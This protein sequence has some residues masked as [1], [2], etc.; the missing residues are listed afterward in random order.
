MSLV[1]LRG[2]ESTAPL[3]FCHSSQEDEVGRV[4][5]LATSEPVISTDTET[6]FSLP[7]EIEP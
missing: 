6:V 4:G 5:V 2:L 3:I 1:F 7:K